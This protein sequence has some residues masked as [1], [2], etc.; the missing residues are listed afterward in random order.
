[1]TWFRLDDGWLRHPK[2]RAAGLHGRA[3]WLAM[4]TYAA[5]QETD[6][7]IPGDMLPSLA[8]EAGV[9]GTVVRT[10]VEVGLVHATPDGGWLLHDWFDYQPSRADIAASRAKKAAAGRKGARQRWGANSTSHDTSHSTSDGTSHDTCDGKPM[11]VVPSRPLVTTSLSPG[12]APQSPVDDDWIE[13]ELQRRLATN[14]ARSKPGSDAHARYLDSIR[15]DIR[16]N[17][18]RPVAPL[19]GPVNRTESEQS[20]ATERALLLAGLQEG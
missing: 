10:L 16:A 11:A 17:G 20:A 3:L 5:G 13:Q 1:M 9:K 19:P 18:R 8:A 12:L 4:G 15:A 2:M 7:Y 6:G 14:P